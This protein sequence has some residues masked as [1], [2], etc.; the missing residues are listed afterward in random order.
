MQQ[1]GYSLVDADG[2]E[3]AFWGDE[4]G[5]CAG[6]PP[7]VCLPNGDPTHGAHLGEVL[8]EK[9]M[10][11]VDE[12]RQRIVQQ[13]VIEEDE[14]GNPVEAIIPQAEPYTEKV[15]HYS[16]GAAY[17]LVERWGRYGDAVGVTFDGDLVI[18]TFTVRPGEV[19]VERD[20]RLQLFTFQGSVFKF[21]PEA[22]ADIASYGMLA[23]EAIS[24]GAIP[25]DLRWYDPDTDFAW[26]AADNT[27]VPMDAHAMLEM[28]RTAARWRSKHVFA[29]RALKDLAPIPAD[30]AGDA[31]WP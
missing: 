13:V 16:D 30:F 18:A 1:I 8:H 5:Q 15:P 24:A 17:R 4:M 10:T 22:R 9:I 21:G 12:E 25:G 29:A 27:H 3:V 6:L 7:V 14:A 20:R 23:L 19:D 11:L 26:I 31:R 28:S 2:K